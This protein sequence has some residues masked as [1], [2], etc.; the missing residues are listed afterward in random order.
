MVGAAAA[1]RGAGAVALLGG[2]RGVPFADAAAEHDLVD[3][4]GLGVGHLDE[5]D[6]GEVEFAGV[7]DLDG[8]DL[9]AGGEAAQ[10]AFPGG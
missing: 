1:Q 4:S 8:E 5:S 6:V 2:R 10:R 3:G 9:V 7:D